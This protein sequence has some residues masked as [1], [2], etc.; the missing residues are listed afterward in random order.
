MF[1]DAL[2]GFVVIIGDAKSD[3]DDVE[4]MRRRRSKMIVI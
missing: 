3:Y 4:L 2:L 1:V